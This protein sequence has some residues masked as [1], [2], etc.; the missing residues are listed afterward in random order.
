[1]Q[2]YDFQVVINCP[3]ETVFSIYKDI[4]RWRNRSV[5]GDIR[6]VQGNPWEEGSR[7]YIETRIPLRSTVDQ[8]IQ[9]FTPNTS[10]SYLSHVYGITCET[11]VTF[12]ALSAERTGIAVG[13]RMIG[14]VSRSFGFAIEP[15]IAK[16]TRSFFEEFRIECEASARKAKSG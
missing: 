10:V 16:T 8:V 11:R 4:D 6:W 14:I 9:Q 15:V 3:L 5:F 7:L 1:M 12:K 2:S 13:M